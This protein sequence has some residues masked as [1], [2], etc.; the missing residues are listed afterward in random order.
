MFVILIFPSTFLKLSKAALVAAVYH[1][2]V[3]TQMMG[4][5]LYIR[6]RGV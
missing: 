4:A 3:I 6:G 1:V 2:L 5:C